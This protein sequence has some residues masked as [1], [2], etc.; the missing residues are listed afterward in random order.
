V[1][2]QKVI[3]YVIDKYGQN[4]VAQIITYGSMKAKTAIKDVARVME[5]PLDESNMLSKLVPEIP[6]VT[7]HQIFDI[8]DNE[9][10]DHFNPDDVTNVKKLR[11]IA[12]SDTLQ[13]RVIREARL[14]EGSVRNAGVHASAVIIAPSD[15]SSIIPVCTLKDSTMWVTQFD[16]RVV[17]DA[18]LL[19]MDFLGLRT[20]TIIKDALEMVKQNHGIEIVLDEIPLD[21]QLTLELFQRGETNGIFQFESDGMKKVLRDLKPTRLEDLIAVNALYRP[22]PME[23]IDSFVKRKHGREKITYDIEEMSEYLEDT[24]G[25]TV[26]Q[27]QVMLLSQKL[28]GFSKG[29]ADT[30]R[31]A[32]GKKDKGTL[33]KMKAQFM[34][35]AEKNGHDLKICEKIWTDWE[36]FASYAFNKSH[37]TCYAYLANQ[38]AYL[39]A[40][41]PSEFMASILTH[42]SNNIDQITFFMDECK[43]MGLVVKG[44]DINESDINF[45]VNKNGEIR[46]G[47]SAIK[48]IGETATIEIIQQRKEGG[49]YSSLF[50]LTSRVSLR[51]VNKKSLEALALAGAF[52][53]W[54]TYN[55][56][57]YI[58]K[59]VNT[60]FTGIEMAIKYGASIQDSKANNQNSLFGEA[61]SIDVP[62]PK[63][64]FIEEWGLIE[65]LNKEK[66]VAGVFISG[67]PLD[68][69]RLDIEL[70]TNTKI[71]ELDSP[72]K[73]RGKE[74]KIAGIVTASD[75]RVTKNGKPWGKFILEDF[76]G[77]KEFT[78]FGEDF[79]K[80]RPFMQLNN[81]LFGYVTVQSRF[82]NP[83]DL[84][85]KFSKISFL[86]DIHESQLKSV[87]LKLD[88]AQV[89]Q[90]TLEELLR[91]T[92]GNKGNAILKISVFDSESSHQAELYSKK[93]KVDW[94]QALMDELTALN[95][96]YKVN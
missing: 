23:Y 50:D 27:E 77:A 70:F 53:G 76:S 85:F 78:M 65:K 95:V 16:G 35:G 6:G 1:G 26:Y 91:I 62:E 9:L 4:Q 64:P 48:G 74:I 18:G 58:E 30:L 37:A 5:L 54:G 20:L 19:K 32:M 81:M 25:I 52:D 10:K 79:A 46:F 66:D 21:D 92:S 71:S 13:S 24:Y 72:E 82:G 75:E 40:H 57:Q 73:L 96:S 3:D 83:E 90:H 80:C 68:D 69:Y 94:N 8:P 84:E 56:A 86:A 55:R 63:I 39:K 93:I 29:N 47:M 45:S 38:T 15:L 41:Y 33:D 61:G 11:E 14:L 89:T 28:A 88:M 67:H 44:P 7:Y 17:E 42:N 49:P 59:G 60:G 31:K 43:R 12:K 34:E 87:N 2:R 51:T 36:A 22:G